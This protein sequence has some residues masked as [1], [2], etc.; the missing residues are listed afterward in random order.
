[1]SHVLLQ[2]VILAFVL[3]VS[4]FANAQESAVELKAGQPGG[5]LL[6]P[7]TLTAAF[8]LLNRTR[9]DFE[10]VRITAISL[11]DGS[12]IDPR[13]LPFEL[14]TIPA[15]HAGNVFAIFRGRSFM[16]KNTYVVK[17][18]GTY[19][20][21]GEQQTFAVEGT[22][23]IPPASPGTEKT[24]AV[25]LV[26]N[27][28]ADVGQSTEGSAP[29]EVDDQD[30]APGIPAGNFH[31]SP[32]VGPPTELSPAPPAG[33]DP[34][35]LEIFRHCVIRDSGG[36]I[37]GGSTNEP[38]GA[39]SD[40]GE[41]ENSD[42]GKGGAKNA[43]TVFATANTFAAL[44]DDDGATFSKLSFSGIPG[45]TGSICCDQVA[46]FV[47][48]I[49]R[50]IWTMLMR[51]IPGQTGRVTVRLMAAS[52]EDLRKAMGQSGWTIWDFTPAILNFKG[53]GSFD[54]PGLA[55]GDNSLYLNFD[56]FGG[57]L[58]C[59]ISLNEIKA[60]GTLHFR[61]TDPTISPLAELGHVTENPRDEVFWAQH[62]SNSQMRVFSWAEGSDDFHF[63]DVDIA[64]WPN[65]PSKMTSSTPDHQ[66]WLAATS[67]GRIRGAA[68][69][70]GTKT[71][72]IWFAWTA[73]RGN[74]FK[75][76]HVHWV[77]LDPSHD[78]KILKQGNVF[79]DHFAFGLP[80]LATNSRGELGMSLET[81]GGGN[82]ENHVVGFQGDHALHL[83]S[84]SKVGLTRFG[85][86]VTIHQ[87]VKNDGR[88][89]AF[90]YGMEPTP[91]THF[92]IFGR[93]QP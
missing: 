47:P 56:G 71:D 91:T 81:G 38:S 11:A 44:S 20:R 57:F 10:R 79:N 36:P 24:I 54:F 80:A 9:E 67:P 23:R 32:P 50:F 27:P 74:S 93:G 5:S 21:E 45:F 73:S 33:V 46:V 51:N 4:P 61:F 75:Q 7:G 2:P 12:R 42:C 41:N 89:D 77:K 53:A 14:G 13:K 19:L 43:R 17:V 87:D 40:S 76:P 6:G 83:T 62:N 29:Q 90:G 69:F 3:F 63:R 25:S 58:V 72:E 8:P 22:L 88:F 55:V 78:F 86:Y 65:D 64:S 28:A 85:D 26:P 48:K 16:P 39:V 60:G 52:P 31:R 84:N 70:K 30:M 68:R 34:A 59:R 37:H 35:D 66:D 1:M 15:G 49:N 92:V 18:A 82:F